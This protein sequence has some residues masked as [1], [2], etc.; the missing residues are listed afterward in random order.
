C[1]FFARNDPLV[2][3]LAVALWELAESDP[4]LR[5]V[6]RTEIVRRPECPEPLVEAA[7]ASG[8]KHL[9][10]IID[11]RRGGGPRHGRGSE[12]PAAAGAAGGGREPAAGRHPAGDPADPGPADGRRPRPRAGGGADR[13]RGVVRGVR[14]APE[15]QALRR[16]PLP[17]RAPRTP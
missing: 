5:W 17:G 16:G 8:L 14:R 7:R 15:R 6:I 9:A 10:R 1:E 3:E 2:P 4:D 11:R 13:L 12:P